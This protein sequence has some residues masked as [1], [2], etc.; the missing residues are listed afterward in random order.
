MGHK[1]FVSYRYADDQVAV[2]NP[3]VYLK[4]P[5]ATMTVRS[6]VDRL[7]EN[8]GKTNIYKGEHD[9]EDLS[10]L[11]DTT[12]ERYLS[13]KIFD[14]SVTVV[15]VSPGM[16]DKSKSEK[17][18]WI[19]WEI[20]MSVRLLNRD[21]RTSLR[22]ALLAVIL[23]DRSGGYA[24]ARNDMHNV[25]PTILWKNIINGY[26]PIVNWNDF[27]YARDQWLE[28]AIHAKSLVSDYDI[29]KMI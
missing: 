19:P 13:K 20:S 1:V 6:Y 21:G 25:M 22:N 26:A 17:E 8:L 14:S 5:F 15:L 23:P 10:Y 18:Q 3:L 16:L 29:V 27:Q 11:A 9:G 24:Y 12:I 28:K 7:E 2:F 4:H